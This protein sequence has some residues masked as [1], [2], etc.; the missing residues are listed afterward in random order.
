MTTQPP[1]SFTRVAMAI[2]VAGLVIG[3]GFLTSSYLGT[4]KTVTN[5]RTSTTTVTASQTNATTTICSVAVPPPQ[6]IYLRV[7][8]DSGSPIAGLPVIVQSTA[9]ASCSPK[10]VHLTDS[11]AVTNSS[12]WILFQGW[13]YYFVFAYSGST[14]NFTVGGDPMAWTVA[15]ISVP[16]GSLTT[17]ICG[18]GGGTLNSSCSNQ[19]TT[20]VSTTMTQTTTTLTPVAADCITYSGPPPLGA[21]LRVLSDSNSSSV[22]GANVTATPWSTYGCEAY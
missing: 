6:G 14:Y 8:N 22:V 19:S 5:T 16:S 13:L 3:A 12:G 20:L 11:I 18:L 10:D 9:N 4:T 21:Y 17:E 1:R 15:T 7:V 2:V